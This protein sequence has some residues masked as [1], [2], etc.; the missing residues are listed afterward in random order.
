MGFIC[1]TLDLFNRKK[2]RRKSL[3]EED[4]EWFQEELRKKIS[5]K[6]LSILVFSATSVRLMKIIRVVIIPV[7][8]RES[9]KDNNN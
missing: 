8:I 6:N 4:K 5:D 7:L 2:K 3:E 9:L 1:L